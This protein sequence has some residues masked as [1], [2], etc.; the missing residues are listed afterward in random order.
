MRKVPD[1][2]CADFKS[3]ESLDLDCNSQ[4]VLCDGSHIH[5]HGHA[6]VVLSDQLRSVQFSHSYSDDLVDGGCVPVSI[7]VL[8][9][10]LVAGCI[11]G[12][13]SSDAYEDTDRELRSG[14]VDLRG[15][16]SAR[17]FSL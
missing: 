2:H 3:I 15:L 14:V 9:E 8:V 10:L 17:I 12:R 11:D 5:I 7:G 1:S 16:L 6:L 13:P 4:G